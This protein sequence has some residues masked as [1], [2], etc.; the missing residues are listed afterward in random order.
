MIK[1]LKIQAEKEAKKLGHELES[2][3]YDPDHG[4][5]PHVA[6]CKLCHSY[7]WVRRNCYGGT[8]IQSRPVRDSYGDIRPVKDRCYGVKR[9]GE[10]RREYTHDRKR[11]IKAFDQGGIQQVIQE[12]LGQYPK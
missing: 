6:Y 9:R 5:G 10:D 7:V 4:F 1:D 11:I 12:V 2:W 3:R 8:A